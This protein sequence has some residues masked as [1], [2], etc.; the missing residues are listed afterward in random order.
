MIKYYKIPISIFI[1]RGESHA[2]K[3]YSFISK[4]ISITKED[5]NMKKLLSLLLTIIMTI[6]LSCTTFASEMSSPTLITLEA[7]SD[8]CDYATSITPKHLHALISSGELSGSI[9]EYSLGQNFSIFNVTNHT[10]ST[11][12]PVIHNETVV[13]LLD[14]FESNGEYSS[15]LSVSFSKELENFFNSKQMDKF[16]LLTDGVRLQAFNG[17]YTIEIFKLF[18]DGEIS[19]DLG[20]MCPTKLFSNSQQTVNLTYNDITTPTEIQPFITTRGPVS[21][22][23]YK[24]IN[25]RGVSQGNHPWCWAATCAALINY[26]KGTSLTASTVANYVFPN[27]PEQ[28]GN[29]S[30]MQKAYNHWYLYPSQSGVASFSTVKSKINSNRPMHLGLIGHS[31]GLIGYEDWTGVPGENNAHILVLLEPNGGVRKSVTLNSSGNFYYAL[32]GSSNA[33]QYTRMF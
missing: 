7:T 4:L 16:V 21:P 18:E 1:K 20:K 10:T 22:K 3:N 23:E 17:Q 13:A 27:N 29:W 9:D 26:Y 5:L 11:C 2:A 31:V 12:F 28:G 19:P 15:S 8:L 30:D 32:S 24:T 6:S 14:V 25:V 33:W